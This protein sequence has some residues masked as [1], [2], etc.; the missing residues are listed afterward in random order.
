MTVDGCNIHNNH[1]GS[2]GG[3]ISTNSDS[4]VVVRNSQ[5]SFN[6][7]DVWGGAMDIY[8][9]GLRTTITNSGF[10]GNNAPSGGAIFTVDSAAATVDR[11]TFMSNRAVDPGTFTPLLPG[12]GGAVYDQGTMT[13]TNSVFTNNFAS[14]VNGGGAI[15]VD[16]AGTL[17]QSRNY[18][19]HN[20][21]NNIAP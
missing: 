7:A 14:V 20:S 1:A 19:V 16:P 11:C 9:S 2:G 8:G 13:I 21:P 15:F 4:T 5:I 3:G 12:N 18:F 6:T 17:T 10:T